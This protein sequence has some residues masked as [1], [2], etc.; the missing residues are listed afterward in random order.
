MDDIHNQN[1]QKKI[2]IADDDERLRTIHTA[3]FQEDGFQV[4]AVRDGQ[5][6]WEKIREGYIPD[7]ILTGIMMPRLDGFGLFS[8]TKDDPQLKHIP[9][10]ILSHR[11]LVEDQTMAEQLGVADFLMQNTTPPS[12]VVRR[13]KLLVGEVTQFRIAADVNRMDGK[14]LANYLNRTRTSG[15]AHLEKEIILELEPEKTAG[16]FKIRIVE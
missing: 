7:I 12:E 10:V 15:Y 11:G 13:C 16:V 4:V 3:V 5:E 9:V 8:K 14:L 2:L 1:Q 6:A